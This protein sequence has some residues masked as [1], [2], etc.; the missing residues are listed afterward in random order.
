[1]G[2]MGPIGCHWIP[3]DPWDPWDP[4]GPCGTPWDP[5]D[6]M[7]PH[8]T[9][10]TPWDPW[11]P[12]DPMEGT[13]VS[14]TCGG[15]FTKPEKR[16][17]GDGEGT[18]CF[19]PSDELLDPKAPLFLICVSYGKNLTVGQAKQTLR[20]TRTAK[21]TKEQSTNLFKAIDMFPIARWWGAP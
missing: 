3:W 9:H 11:D 15:P 17:S 12:W 2:S 14:Y 20:T 21:A 6:P 5:W 10:G 16:R 18:L 1:M 4:M 19:L 7:G 13:S 8:G